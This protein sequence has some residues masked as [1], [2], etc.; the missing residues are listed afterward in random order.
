ML[1]AVQPRSQ[2][3]GGG[4]YV[5]SGLPNEVGGDSFVAPGA[6]GSIPPA[7]VTGRVKEARNDKGTNV[8]VPYARVVPRHH[9][10]KKTES[11]VHEYE[12]EYENLR[13]GELAWVLGRRHD[14]EYHVKN[15]KF[16]GNGVDRM[17]RLASTS[18]MEATFKQ[19]HKGLEICLHTLEFTRD[20]ILKRS[21]MLMPT[22]M[23]A[24]V[25]LGTDVVHVIAGLNKTNGNDTTA[26]KQIAES[27]K[28]YQGIFVAEQGPFLRGMQIDNSGVKLDELVPIM[29]ETYAPRNMGD[30]MAFEVLE[31]ELMKNNLFDWIPD[32]IVLSKLESPTGE[33]E[34]SAALD[35]RDGQLVNIGIKGPSLTTVWTSDV[36][37]FRL[38]CQP[39]D[40]VFICL[41]ADLTW[42]ASATEH[43]FRYDTAS[44]LD[45][46]KQT[47]SQLAKMLASVSDAKRSGASSSQLEDLKQDIRGDILKELEDLENV[48]KTRRQERHDS[49]PEVELPDYIDMHG[50]RRM[51]PKKIEELKTYRS[52]RE[53]YHEWRAEHSKSIRTGN[54]LVDDARLSN[55]RLMRSTS[56]HF[57]NYSAYKRGNTSS[58]C[59]LHLGDM[60]DVS[61]KK[62]QSVTSV[63]CCGEYIVGGWCIGTVLDS[64]AS[65]SVAGSTVRNT[66]T[67]TELNVNVDI[68]WWSGDRLFSAFMDKSETTMSRGQNNTKQLDD[69]YKDIERV[70]DDIMTMLASRHTQSLFAMTTNHV[71]NA[72]P[73]QTKIG[74]RI[75]VQAAIGMSQERRVRPRRA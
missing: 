12:Y 75:G 15:V 69:D 27:E 7:V 63:E 30:R 40:K 11:A 13:K 35:A 45:L 57:S 46:A 4:A 28:Q 48:W 16:Q 8:Q 25:L 22:Q 36:Q 24:N 31:D 23:F 38:V 44:A 54:L 1:S 10:T 55:F 39:L 53:R 34:T 60:M 67:T 29:K 6:S 42:R 70:D 50:E 49:F 26:T 52:T 68:E 41:V 64:A 56:S 33:R 3:F 32:G 73:A 43:K 47:E 58:R 14:D 9:H 72:H 51:D 2:G 71:A 65:R 62:D 37:N 20:N 18:W 66:A 17:Q 5:A 61:D 19:R 59:G 21:G 74:S